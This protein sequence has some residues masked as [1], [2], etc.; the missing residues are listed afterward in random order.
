M[1]HSELFGI[2]LMYYSFIG[3]LFKNLAV[4]SILLSPLLMGLICC[5]ISAPVA[6]SSQE[7]KVKCM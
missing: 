1:L 3:S 4:Y 6:L 5:N 7:F 2:M